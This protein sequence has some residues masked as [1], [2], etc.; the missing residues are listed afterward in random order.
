[1]ANNW[2]KKEGDKSSLRQV[3]GDDMRQLRVKSGFVIAVA[4]N[5]R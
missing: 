2:Q 3:D 1:M 5:F 4:T